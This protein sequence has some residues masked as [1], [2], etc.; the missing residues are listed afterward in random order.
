MHMQL[1]QKPG[2]VPE[3]KMDTAVELFEREEAPQGRVILAQGATCNRL[4]IVRGGIVEAMQGDQKAP[5]RES[6]G[7]TFFGDDAMMVSACMRTWL[8][9]T[10]LACAQRP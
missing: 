7:F 10:G 4:Y 9:L 2:A 6:G 3:E 5:L 1:C 8:F